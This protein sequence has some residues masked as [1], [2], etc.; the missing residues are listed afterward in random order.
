M[1]PKIYRIEFFSKYDPQISDQDSRSRS[2]SSFYPAACRRRKIASLRRS[3]WLRL[4]S[5]SWNGYWEIWA[6]KWTWK[7]RPE[8]SWLLSWTLLRIVRTSWWKLWL[9]L[10]PMTSWS[11]SRAEW[12]KVACHERAYGFLHLDWST[13]WPEHRSS[14]RQTVVVRVDR[15]DFLAC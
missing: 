5:G 12:T 3:K 9:Q 8:A 15:N 2:L 6:G 4:C 14:Y 10:Q 1:S 13:K 7:R 11:R